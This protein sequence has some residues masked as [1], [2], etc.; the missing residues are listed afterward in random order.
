MGVPNNG[1]NFFSVKFQVKTGVVLTVS[2][3]ATNNHGPNAATA[4]VNALQPGS[5]GGAR[6]ATFGYKP[7]NSLRVRVRVGL[8][9]GLGDPD[10]AAAR[11]I[12]LP[13]AI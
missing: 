2:F 4:K 7:A 8:M 3:L 11:Q 5:F 9:L 10:Q 12:K 6:H 13:R 1:H